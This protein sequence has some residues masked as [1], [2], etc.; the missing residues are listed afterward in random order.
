LYS[1]GLALP[2]PSL[3]EE[4]EYPDIP[5]EDWYR[6][7]RRVGQSLTKDY[8]WYVEPFNM[9]AVDPCADNSQTT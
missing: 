8:Y 7:Q 2:V 1:T 3:S 9:E 5:S 6:I 4:G